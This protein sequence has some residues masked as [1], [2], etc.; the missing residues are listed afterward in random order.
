MKASEKGKTLVLCCEIGKRIVDEAVFVYRQ[1][2]KITP[3]F[4]VCL[5]SMHRAM[6]KLKAHIEQGE[7]LKFICV[8]FRDS[9][10]LTNIYINIQYI[11]TKMNL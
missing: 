9:M 4:C 1:N 8:S 7:E 2:R 11:K 5:C 10:E 6:V 3:D